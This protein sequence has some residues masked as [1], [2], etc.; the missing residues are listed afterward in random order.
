MLIVLSPSKSMDFD[1]TPLQMTSTPTH[2]EDAHELVGVLQSFDRAGLAELMSLSENLTELNFERYQR[3]GEVVEAPKQAIFAYTG[4]T[5]RDIP[6]GDYTEDDLQE[7]QRR[8]RILSGLY[9]A[10]RPLDLIQ[11]YRLEMSTRLETERG[12]S[13]YEFWGDRITHT[14]AEDMEAAGADVLVNLA[15]KEYFKS[16]D[17]EALGARVIE[18]VFKDYKKGK[19]KI[20]SFYAKRMRGAMADFIVR[21]RI[22]D[23]AQLREFSAQGYQWDEERSTEDEPVFLRNQE[24]E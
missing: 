2:L 17:T 1:P 20:I 3:F 12:D 21:N 10:L 24:E 14:L 4:D 8:V 11:P 7:A 23:P 16:I 9:G 13:L 15:S 6:L 18:P 22:E 5:Y 19:Y